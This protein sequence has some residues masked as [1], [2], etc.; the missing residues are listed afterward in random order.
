MLN[1]YNQ[2]CFQNILDCFTGADG[3]LRFVALKSLLECMQN[4]STDTSEEVLHIMRKFSYLIDVA[5]KRTS[6]I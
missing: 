2:K 4:E 3:G 6:S 1:E 5:N